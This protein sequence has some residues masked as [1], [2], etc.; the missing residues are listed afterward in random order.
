VLCLSDVV[1]APQLSNSQK[2]LET[3]PEDGKCN[4]KTGRSYHT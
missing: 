3:L 1:R 4:A 2:A